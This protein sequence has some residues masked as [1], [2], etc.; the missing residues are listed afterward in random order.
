MRRLAVPLLAL[1]A[2]LAFACA[3]RKSST[4]FRLPDGDPARGQAVFAEMKCHTCHRVAGMDKTFPAPV[5]DPPVPV[6]L[7]GEIA[8]AK[9]DGELVTSIIHPSWQ[10]APA[11]ATELQM[12]GGVRD[13]MPD[14]T[15]A[16]TV[17]QMIDLVAFLQSRYEVVRP[18]A[19]M[20]R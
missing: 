8:H 9:T 17:R 13:R 7:G 6:V 15:Q 16:M 1:A 11:Y 2:A 3:D 4:G 18:P 12:K 19:P 10:I 20:G 14:F 5:A